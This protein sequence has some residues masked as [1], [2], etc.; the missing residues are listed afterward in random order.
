MVE[1]VLTAVAKFKGF[2]EGVKF[3]S[4]WSGDLQ[5][6]TKTQFGWADGL[7]THSVNMGYVYYKSK[8]AEI[9]E[10]TIPEYVK[11]IGNVGSYKIGHMASDGHFRDI[12]NTVFDT[13]VKPPH[14]F[15]GANDD[16]KDI[17]NMYSYNFQVVSKA[18]YDAQFQKELTITLDG[19][20]VNTSYWGNN[21]KI[22]YK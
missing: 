17:W 21:V 20:V 14:S 3:K 13:K 5:Q 18:E 22:V 11:L 8:W 12:K 9:V 15:G 10:N 6:M 16:W 2:R 19:D 7:F 1:K 4:A